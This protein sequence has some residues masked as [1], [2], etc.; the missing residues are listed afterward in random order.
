MASPQHLLDRLHA[1]GVSLATTEHALA[2]I[3]LG[4]VGVELDRLDAYSDLDFYVLAKDGYKAWFLNDLTWLNRIA[5]VAYHFQNTEDGYK[6]LYQDGVFCEFAVFEQ[7]E[8]AA[9]PFRAYPNNPAARK[10]TKA[11]AKCR[12]AR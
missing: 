12:K 11:Q 7:A 6:V 10:A 1:I 9:M 3:A 2:L 4:S 8:L 5:P